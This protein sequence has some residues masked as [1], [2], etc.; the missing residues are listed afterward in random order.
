VP[1]TTVVVILL[2]GAGIITLIALI[3]LA[4]RRSG[5][6]QPQTDSYLS[7]GMSLGMLIGAGLGT[8]AWVLTEEFVF[9]VIFMGGGLSVGLAL[10]SARSAGRL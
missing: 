4:V 10:G 2:L 1:E 6:D 8:I 9:W 3:A 7:I 5:T